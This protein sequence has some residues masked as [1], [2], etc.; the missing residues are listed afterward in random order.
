MNA[1]LWTQSTSPTIPDDFVINGEV[2]KDTLSS[3]QQ[4]VFQ[5]LL[6]C[7]KRKGKNPL[8][9][10]ELHRQ[11][12]IESSEFKIILAEKTIF[13]QGHYITL[14]ESGRKIPF[15]FLCSTNNIKEAIQRWEDDSNKIGR[16][17]S[18]KD[19]AAYELIAGAARENLNVKTET[20]SGFIILIS[21]IIIITIIIYNYLHNE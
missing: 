9:I 17:I 14:D 2:Q 4:E 8:Q 11:N 10:E 5:K 3:R 19:K 13:F 20:K 7:A 1:Y 21:L 18:K 16:T 15:M 6:A 12:K